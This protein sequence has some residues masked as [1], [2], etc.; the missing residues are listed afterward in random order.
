ML[1]H[2]IF[3]EMPERISFFA[4]P[5][6]TADVFLRKNIRELA[7]EAAEENEAGESIETGATGATG[8]TDS[9]DATG[10]TGEANESETAARWEADEAYMRCEHSL[11]EI[12][13][14]FDAAFAL[15]AEWKQ[16]G[17]QTR[18]ASELERIELLEKEN[19]ELF[20]QLTDA[21]LALCELYESLI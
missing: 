21:Q 16:G 14:D 20:R 11:A 13:A 15:A 1:N 18:Q 5:D 4:L 12:E 6:G 2:V 3:S 9:T 17:N 8:A 19:A 7:S 10:A